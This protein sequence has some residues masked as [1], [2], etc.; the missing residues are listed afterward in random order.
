MQC[1]SAPSRSEVN[2][3]HLSGSHLDI[4]V[5]SLRNLRHISGRRIALWMIL[6]ASTV[7]LHLMWNSAIFAT[8]QGNDYL[9]IGTSFD[10]LHDGNFDC[11]NELS[12]V[13]E[14]DIVTDVA[15]EMYDDARNPAIATTTMYRLEPKECIEQYDKAIQAEWSN[16]LVVFNSSTSWACFLASSCEIMYEQ[17]LYPP[18]PV[19]VPSNATTLFV[20]NSLDSSPFSMSSHPSF[21]RSCNESRVRNDN[22]WTIHFSRKCG[23]T[24]NLNWSTYPES[25][26][27]EIDYCL[28]TKA[29]QACKLSFSLWI[30]IVVIL[31]NLVKLAAT[32]FAFNLIKEDHLVTLGDAVASFLKTFDPTTTGWSSKNDSRRTRPRFGSTNIPFTPPYPAKKPSITTTRIKS[33]WFY[34]VPKG[35]LSLI[36]IL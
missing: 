21:D 25:V 4:G 18:G 11:R 29:P 34:A 6:C 5:P 27:I 10:V 24:P 26:A 8:L 19:P 23:S 30:M 3:A 12:H 28:A 7:P 1:L 32:I 31:C 35:R 36:Y 20:E 2:K 33:K 17:D 13:Y 9:V 14:A 16:L 22:Y 15:C